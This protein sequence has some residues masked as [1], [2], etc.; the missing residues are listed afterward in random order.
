MATMTK[1]EI[2][3]LLKANPIGWLATVEG[4]KPR[5]RAMG[6]YRIDE[7]GIVFQ[8]WTIK[9]VGKQLMKNPEVE[10]CFNDLKGGTQV[11]VS[12]KVEL[13]QDKALKE[14][15]LAKR[16]MM[17]PMVEARGGMD[18]VAMFHLKKGK[19]TVWTM[20]ANFDPKTYVEL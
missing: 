9:D 4:N 1:A 2:L 13:I 20:A 11:R 7:E 10:I 18:V 6:M 15:W 12:G 3:A 8:S 16:P 14:E 19:A 5:V 17:K